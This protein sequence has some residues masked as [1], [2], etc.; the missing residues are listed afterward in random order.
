MLT[1]VGSLTQSLTGATSLTNQSLTGRVGSLTQS[2]AGGQGSHT[3]QSL[4]GGVYIG[5]LIQPLAAATSLID[6][7]LTGG[8]GALTQSLT[9]AT[10]LTDQSLTDQSLTGAT[11]L[12]DQSLTEAVGSLAQLHSETALLLPDSS[13]V[14]QSTEKS[15]YICKIATFDSLSTCP[16]IT[17]LVTI[18]PDLC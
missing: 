16:I 5:S 18:M 1:E 9:G 13:W 11:S 3:D 17:H 4:T 8:V 15:L 2:L 7:S 12:T 10:S 6:Q 14:D